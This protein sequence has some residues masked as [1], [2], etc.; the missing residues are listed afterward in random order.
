MGGFGS[1]R[2]SGSGRDTVEACRSLDV[3]RLHR[4]G[5]LRAGWCG[6]LAMDPRRRA[7]RIDQPARRGR[8]AAS[9]LSRAHRRRRLG[10]R[11]RDRPH[12]PRCLPL[13]RL[14]AVFHLSRR[15][16]RCRLRAARRQAAPVGALFPVPA[17]HGS[18]CQ[19]ERGRMGPRA[20][21]RQ[22]DQAAPRRRSRHGRAVPAEAER[23][24]AADLQAPARASVSRPRCSPTKPSSSGPSSCWR[25]STTSTQR[26]TAKGVS[27]DDRDQAAL[28][29]ETGG[30]EITRFNALRHGV[31][32]RYTVLPWEDARRIPG[33]GRRAR[34]RARAAGADRGA[35]GRGAGRHL[36]AQAPAAPGR[37]RRPPARARGHAS[38]P[39]A[40]P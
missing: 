2:P 25:G 11:G 32:S 13:R 9:H 36:V 16:E 37:G 22:Q 40:R 21:P 23:H 35:S 7:G 18:P 10:G 19:P 1:G 24:V 3:N 17:C 12:R 26:R 30:T 39:T 29:A 15:G 33:P 6:R 31:L 28:P 4:E 34:R 27:G 38:P 20:A 14:T 8:P 5:C